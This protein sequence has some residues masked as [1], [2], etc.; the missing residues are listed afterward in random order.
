MPDL[1]HPGA[2]YVLGLPS[3][4]CYSNVIS[5]AGNRSRCAARA[6]AA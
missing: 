4:S 2:A 1:M 5:A 6:S 3:G